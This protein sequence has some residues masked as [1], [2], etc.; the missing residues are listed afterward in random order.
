[1][2]PKAKFCSECAA[3]LSPKPPATP[4]DAAVQQASPTPTATADGERRHRLRR[5]ALLAE[6]EQPA[7][8]G[9]GPVADAEQCFRRAI[10]VTRSQQAKSLELRAIASLAR[11]LRRQGRTGE[12]RDLLAPIHGWFTEGFD[13]R[14]LIDAKTLLEDLGS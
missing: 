7:A 5:E 11:L 2:P 13:T 6:N 3:P 10:E 14:D 12:A 9:T 8:D 1:V 4:R